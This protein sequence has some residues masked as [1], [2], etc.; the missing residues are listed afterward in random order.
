MTARVFRGLR[1]NKINKLTKSRNTISSGEDTKSSSRDAK[2]RNVVG[3]VWVGC[4]CSDV[5]I[6]VC[7]FHMLVC[8]HVRRAT[9]VALSHVNRIMS[10]LLLPVLHPFLSSLHAFFLLLFIPLRC[11]IF[12]V[13]ELKT[14]KRRGKC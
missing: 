1:K 7:A 9:V 3:G 6:C 8:S 11:V 12:G 13:T 10:L 2:T 4:F 5:C 14:L